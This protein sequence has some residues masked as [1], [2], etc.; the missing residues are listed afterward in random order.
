MSPRG[1]FCPLGVKFSVHPSILLI[2]RDCSPLGVN[3]RMNISPREQI[4]P[5]GA[6]FDPGAKFNP[7][8]RDEVKNGPQ[9]FLVTLAL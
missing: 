9:A 7:G 2:S 6:K 3:E 5:L 8:A 1:E 4:S